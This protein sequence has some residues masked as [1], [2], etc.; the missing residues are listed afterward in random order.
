[1]GGT[2]PDLRLMKQVEQVTG[3]FWKDHPGALPA[4]RTM[5]IT[6]AV[7]VLAFEFWQSLLGCYFAAKNSDN[8]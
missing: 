6:G 8:S 2:E 1:M 4:F 5:G 7:E 3:W